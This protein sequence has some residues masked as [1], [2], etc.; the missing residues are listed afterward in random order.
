MSSH[1]KDFLFLS[2]KGIGRMVYSGSKF[3]R[4]WF[5]F[6]LICFGTEGSGPHGGENL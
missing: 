2:L 5:R 6:A 4:F 1:P 3:Q